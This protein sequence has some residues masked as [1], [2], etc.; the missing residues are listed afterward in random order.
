VVIEDVPLEIEAAKWA[1]MKCVAL[2]TTYEPD[3]KII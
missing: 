1:G 3:L 2:A